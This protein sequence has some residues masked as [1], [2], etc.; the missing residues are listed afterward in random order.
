MDVDQ[1]LIQSQNDQLRELISAL[2]LHVP[3]EGHHAERVS[4]Y[5]TATGEKLGLD[6]RTLIDL[7][8][9]ALLHDVGKIH[10]RKELLTKPEAL[11]AHDW[12]ELK[13]HADHAMR[14]L[15]SLAWLSRSIP[16]I[17]HHHEWFNGQGYPDGLAGDSI[18]LGARIISVAEAFDVLV[19]GL[20]MRDSWAE[21][22]AM[23]EIRRCTGTQFDPDVV[24]A[25]SQVQPLIQPLR[26]V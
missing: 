25:F 1:L 9:A 2:D 14:V 24:A 7:R 6:D 21:D 15:E 22:H 4:V 13:L 11:T 19:T 26:R 16:M 12:A 23:A 3:G 17:R 18:P 10:V 20:Y 5:A 8:R